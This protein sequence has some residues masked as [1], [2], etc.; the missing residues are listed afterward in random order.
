MDLN[1][2]LFHRQVSQYRATH[3]ASIDARLRHVA[4]T[5]RLETLIRKRVPDSPSRRGAAMIE[6]LRLA[7]E[8]T[9]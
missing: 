6:E 4:D 2:L 7:M 3:A 5:E 9:H 1:Y 8:S